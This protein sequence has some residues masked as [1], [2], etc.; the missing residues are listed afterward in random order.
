MDRLKKKKFKITLQKCTPRQCFITYIIQYDVQE[1]KVTDFAIEAKKI[2][3]LRLVD[4]HWKVADIVNQ[5]TYIE[6]KQ[7]IN[8]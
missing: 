3:E 7:S 8:P 6:A 2:A 1:V 4:G 5:K